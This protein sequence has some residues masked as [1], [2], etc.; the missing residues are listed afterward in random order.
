MSGA[1]PMI[2]VVDAI[3]AMAKKRTRTAEIPSGKTGECSWSAT[4]MR[5]QV[6]TDYSPDPVISILDVLS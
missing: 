3:M 2:F 1:S 4:N 6:R 5:L